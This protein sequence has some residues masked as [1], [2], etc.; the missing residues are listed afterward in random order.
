[1]HTYLGVKVYVCAYT[2]TT[3]SMKFGLTQAFETFWQRTHQSEEHHL[4]LSWGV[5]TNLT[6][7]FPFIYCILEV[8]NTVKQQQLLHFRK[9]AKPCCVPLL[10]KQ[11]SQK[12][13]L[14]LLVTLCVFLQNFL[15]LICLTWFFFFFFL[16]TLAPSPDV[17]V[18]CGGKGIESWERLCMANRLPNKKGVIG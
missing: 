6:L 11:V 17:L 5:D 16:E 4:K 14:C 15:L 18:L 2:H 1:M 13:L 10:D 9:L 3:M 7:Y 8:T 12:S